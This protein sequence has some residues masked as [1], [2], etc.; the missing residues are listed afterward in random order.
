M[1]SIYLVFSHGLTRKSCGDHAERIAGLRCNQW[2]G[3][4]CRKWAPIRM[5]QPFLIAAAA[6]PPAP[7][8]VLPPLWSRPFAWGLFKL[9][10]K[11]TRS[12][13]LSRSSGLSL[14][15][16]SSSYAGRVAHC[17]SIIRCLLVKFTDIVAHC[18]RGKGTCLSLANDGSAH[19]RGNR[20]NH[21]LLLL[22]LLVLWRW[23]RRR[24]LKVL[25]KEKR[26]TSSAWKHDNVSCA[27]R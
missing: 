17:R 25:R 6:P 7:R 19:S 14:G 8:A 3:G 27:H 26:R 24:E 4:R 16:Q 12:N 11:N 1:S 10:L 22:V 21:A 13:M 15:P 23:W 18:I 9:R 2:P 20:A 5:S